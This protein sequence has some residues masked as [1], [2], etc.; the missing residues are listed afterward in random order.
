MI[1]LVDRDR[2]TAC[3]ECVEVCPPEAIVIVDGSAVIEKRFCEECGECVDACPEE[4]ISLGA[5]A[6]E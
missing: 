2:C 3:G 6:R 4:A 5:A 1:P